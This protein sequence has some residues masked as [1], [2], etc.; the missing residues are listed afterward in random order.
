MLAQLVEEQMGAAIS[1]NQS[2]VKHQGKI[3]KK[4]SRFENFSYMV[5]AGDEMV[6]DVLGKLIGGGKRARNAG[7]DMADKASQIGKLCQSVM[8][9]ANSLLGCGFGPL[10]DTAREI[11]ARRDHDVFLRQRLTNLADADAKTLSDLIKRNTNTDSRI[12]AISKTIFEV[13]MLALSE[14]TSNMMLASQMREGL[15]DN[16]TNMALSMMYMNADGNMDWTVFETELDTMIKGRYE[17]A[18]V[19]RAVAAARGADV[20]MG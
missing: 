12:R 14:L 20:A 9:K 8:M 2:W 16:Y 17:Q 13:E 18:G 15:Y 3:V 5:L 1:H 10:Q 7:G 4:M 11:T 6:F 19:Q